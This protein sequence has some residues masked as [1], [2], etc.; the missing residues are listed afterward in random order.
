MYELVYRGKGGYN[1]LEDEIGIDFVGAMRIALANPVH[2]ERDRMYAV[3]DFTHEEW[4]S[5]LYRAGCFESNAD[6]FFSAYP[7]VGTQDRYACGCVSG[8]P[9]WHDGDDQMWQVDLEHL[10]IVEDAWPGTWF[11]LTENGGLVVFWNIQEDCPACRKHA[12]AAETAAEFSGMAWKHGLSAFSR[13]HTPEEAAERV[14]DI[15]AHPE[16]ELCVTEFE[17]A[18]GPFGLCLN[19]ELTALYNDDAWSYVDEATGERLPS[20]DCAN[21]IYTT[22]EFFEE[23]RNK[24]HR[25][26]EGFL[27]GVKVAY[28]WIREEFAQR[29]RDVYEALLRLAKRLGVRLLI[30]GSEEEKKASL[31]AARDFIV[32]CAN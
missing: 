17:C 24:Y 13:T 8:Y 18:I 6:G 14:E 1:Y 23:C 32:R 29:C 12:A 30:E 28:L 27:K 9:E 2:L 16:W 11:K 3:G 5:I 20:D 10:V 19:G 25:Y 26:F 31:E 4:I 21:Q 22:E 15:L 7:L